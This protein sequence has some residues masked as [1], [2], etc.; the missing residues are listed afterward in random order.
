MLIDK[1]T[2]LKSLD[3]S[4]FLAFYYS[5]R[6]MDVIISCK[7]KI[8]KSLVIFDQSTRSNDRIHLFEGLWSHNDVGRT[9][10][11][12]QDG[13]VQL[14]D[15]CIQQNSIAL[16]LSELDH[17]ALRIQI[18]HDQVNSTFNLTWLLAVLWF[19][20]DFSLVSSNTC[21]IAFLVE[22]SF[23]CLIIGLLISTVLNT[24][25][26]VVESIPCSSNDAMIL[27]CRLCVCCKPPGSTLWVV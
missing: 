9:W 26:H 23:V 25:C 22:S 12:F 13:F 11:L 4:C 3:G 20:L 1:Y 8:V 16:L 5:L 19:S 10:I 27:K 15:C 2:T 6:K 14:L 18:R 17:A 7:K 21:S 24:M